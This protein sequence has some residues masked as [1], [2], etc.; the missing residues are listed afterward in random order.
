MR[1]EEDRFF[2][3]VF[4]KAAE[5][6]P[7]VIRE[8]ARL[9]EPPELAP[10]SGWPEP[11]RR[12]KSLSNRTVAHARSGVR[13]GADK[14]GLPPVYT[15]FAPYPEARF[16]FSEGAAPDF[17]PLLST[18]LD[19]A[20]FNGLAQIIT[21]L[22]SPRTR[23]HERRVD[24]DAVSTDLY[25]GEDG[26]ALL[27]RANRLLLT[28]IK[29]WWLAGEGGFVGAAP[30]R[31]R[32]EAA[33]YLWSPQ[34][35]GCAFCLRCGDQIL[36]LRAA[37][38]GGRSAPICA[39]CVRGGSL[40]WP[41]HAVAPAERGTWWLRCLAQGCTNAFVGRA[42]ARRC[43]ACRTSRR[44]ISKRTPLVPMTDE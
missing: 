40:E 12:M 24:G 30:Y 2:Q 20:L 7:D 6:D 3:A 39:R 25:P 15:G 23:K 41:A 9:I 33:R 19:A 1:R 44:A 32:Y 18:C 8:L 11:D 35:A 16:E 21:H 28:E 38:A 36:Y 5:V 31:V 4:K 27:E 29:L 42:Q 26:R 34:I 14:L 22:H 37:R 13:R 10:L 17:A 43:P